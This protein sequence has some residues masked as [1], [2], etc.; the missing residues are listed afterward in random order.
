MFAVI[1]RH[2]KSDVKLT[3]PFLLWFYTF[4]WE[5]ISLQFAVTADLLDYIEDYI[6]K[7]LSRTGRLQS[8]IQGSENSYRIGKRNWS[9]KTKNNA[10]VQ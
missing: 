6:K 10:P 9:G 2:K 7:Q 5:Y 1:C 8:A 4:L 3:E